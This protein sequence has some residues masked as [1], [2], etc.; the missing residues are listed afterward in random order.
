[1]SCKPLVLAALA[2]LL[3]FASLAQAQDVGPYKVLKI[4]L[5]DGDG[6]FDYVTADPDGRNPV[7]YT[8]LDVYKRQRPIS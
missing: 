1:M 7:S 3:P 8:H 5:V 2:V 4:Q 6:G